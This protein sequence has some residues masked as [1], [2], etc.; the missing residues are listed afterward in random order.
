[1][2]AFNSLRLCGAPRMPSATSLTPRLL[3]IND[4]HNRPPSSSFSFLNSRQIIMSTD[5]PSTP[6]MSLRSSRKKSKKTGEAR[7]PT[8]VYGQRLEFL[9]A[10][11]ARREGKFNLSN[12][13]KTAIDRHVL[14]I[15]HIQRELT[16]LYEADTTSEL[17][18]TTHQ[19]ISSKE[20]VSGLPSGFSPRSQGFST[21]SP[22]LQFHQSLPSRPLR[23]RAP[24]QQQHPSINPS[25]STTLTK[26]IPSSTSHVLPSTQRPNVSTP[27]PSTIMSQP[28]FY[29][30]HAEPKISE[31]QG[32][33]TSPVWPFAGAPPLQKPLDRMSQLGNKAKDMIVSP[34]NASG[35]VPEPSPQYIA[36]CNLAPQ[37]TVN[38]QDLL[39]VID[40]NGTLLYRPDR[41]KTFTFIER[42]HTQQFLNFVL[43]NFS[44]MI[45]SSARPENVRRMCKQL[46]T[47]ERRKLLVAEW[48]R[49]RRGLSAEDYTKR[50]QCYKRLSRIWNDPVIQ[51]RHPRSGEGLTWHQGNTIL[52]DDSIEKSRSEPYNFVEVIEFNGQPE[53]PNILRDL[54][55]YLS[56]LRTQINVS[57]FI[58]CH[59]LKIVRDTS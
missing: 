15:A 26:Q 17:P 38:H 47:Q 34:S 18:A 2:R 27:W 41:T 7:T 6:S 57:S 32:S 51:A 12:K 48:G 55:Q 36:S 31:P 40:L 11:L 23:P 45:W 22:A 14:E 21:K 24:L 53:D 46:F 49:D 1:M 13:K 59:P 4:A 35:G 50:V 25:G 16:A 5:V 33:Q 30:I 52:L 29:E 39:V 44:V 58:R 56:T 19:S 20:A 42:P 43:A 10:V 9:K 54:A 8:E 37:F 3:V 28:S